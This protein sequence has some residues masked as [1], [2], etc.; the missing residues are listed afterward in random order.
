MGTHPSSQL[1]NYEQQKRLGQVYAQKPTEFN[2]AR[3]VS[4]RTYENVVVNQPISEVEFN[5]RIKRV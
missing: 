1:A 5:S 4:V 2:P 3:Y